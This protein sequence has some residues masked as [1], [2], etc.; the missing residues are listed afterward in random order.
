MCMLRKSKIMLNQHRLD[1]ARV[2][3]VSD[4]ARSSGK[5]LHKS[6][7]RRFEKGKL[8]SSFKNI[9]WGAELI[10]MH[11]IRKFQRAF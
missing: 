3:K 7:I 5:E 2:A 9:I 8:Y 1:L 4:R 6:L 10:D 11:L